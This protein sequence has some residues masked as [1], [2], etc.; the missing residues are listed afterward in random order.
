MSC[1]AL[2]GPKK[3]IRVEKVKTSGIIS[4]FFSV[5]KTFLRR[6]SQG[7]ERD[8]EQAKQEKERRRKR[9]KQ[10]ETERREGEE[11]WKQTDQAGKACVLESWTDVIEDA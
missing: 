9:K 10:N 11:S 7:M 1:R 8:Q 3:I 2:K 6:D 4:A 5:R